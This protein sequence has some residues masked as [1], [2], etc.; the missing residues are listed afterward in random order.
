MAK[1]QK[2][3]AL[4]GGSRLAKHFRKGEILKSINGTGEYKLGR[5][6]GTGGFGLIYDATRVGTKNDGEYVAKIEPISNG[7][8]FNELHVLQKITP[9]STIN[10]YMREKSLSRHLA[11][12]ELIAGGVHEYE[13]KKYRFIILPKYG[14]DLRKVFYRYGS[15]LDKTT[16]YSIAIQILDA[17]EYIHHHGIVHE[18]IKAAN[19]L[20]QHSN[21]ERQ[22]R[23]ADRQGLA[24]G[25]FYLIDFG[26]ATRFIRNN[27]HRTFDESRRKAHRGTLYYASLQSHHGVALSR[28][29]DLQNL[30]FCLLEWITGRLPWKKNSWKK[31]PE[32]AIKV[33][34]TKSK[35]ALMKNLCRITDEPLRQYFKEVNKLKYEEK[36]NYEELRFIFRRAIENSKRRLYDTCN[37]KRKRDSSSSA[38]KKQRTS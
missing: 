18:D 1:I 35:E 10:D 6:I 4:G 24:I 28:S 9:P 36:P 15:V 32:K 34:V 30:G 8:L 27:K 26:L 38:S 7:A 25:K 19:I 22:R 5:L 37:R 14:D 29:G 11:I 2:I 16:V 33:K 13:G 20:L 3:A 21:I 17:I 31:L 23:T 12:P